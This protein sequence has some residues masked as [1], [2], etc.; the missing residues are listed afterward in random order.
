MQD[1]L[2]M[3]SAIRRPRLLV[4]AARHGLAEYQRERLLPRLLMR[5]AAPAGSNEALLALMELEAIADA[6]RRA[7]ATEYSYPAH[8]EVLIALMGESLLAR[9][10]RAAQN[11]TDTPVT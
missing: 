3:V 2:T 8:V 11:P 10:G 9:P 1:I 4:R 5:P 6:A 7:R